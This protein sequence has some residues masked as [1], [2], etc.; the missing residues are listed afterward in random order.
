VAE[1]SA[2]ISAEAAAFTQIV[3]GLVTCATITRADTA[4]LFE[5]MA[6]P[7]P[8]SCMSLGD[9]CPDLFPPNPLT[10]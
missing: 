8:A 10:Q 4:A 6:S 2:C 3:N 1:Y 5:V 9:K 7:P